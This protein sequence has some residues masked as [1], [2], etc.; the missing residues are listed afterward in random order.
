MPRKKGSHV[1]DKARI[2]NGTYRTRR[3]FFRLWLHE[4]CFSGMS[5]EDSLSAYRKSC[6]QA[7]R[8]LRGTARPDCKIRRNPVTIIRRPQLYSSKDDIA[9]WNPAFIRAKG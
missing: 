3:N 9:E 7:S 8:I 2:R 5:I 4:V 1:D 6:E